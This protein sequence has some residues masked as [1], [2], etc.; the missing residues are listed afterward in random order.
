M[1]ADSLG[2]T[3]VGYLAKRPI[4]LDSVLVYF[5]MGKLQTAD[6]ILCSR[7]KITEEHFDKIFDTI[8]RG[9]LFTVQKAL[10]SDGAS[11][12]TALGVGAVFLSN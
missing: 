8:V 9:L 1:R 4:F 6:K 12:R 10:P 3:Y 2:Q 11:V 7:A 5:F